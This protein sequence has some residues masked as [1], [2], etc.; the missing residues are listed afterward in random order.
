MARPAGKGW[1]CRGREIRR[2]PVSENVPFPCIS[3][4]VYREKG[5]EDLSVPYVKRTVKAGEVIETW[6]GH[7]P[8]VHPNGAKRAK[9]FKDTEKAQMDANERRAE[10]NLRWQLNANFSKNDMHVVLQYWEKPTSIDEMEEDARKFLSVL[11]KECKKFGIVLKYVLAFETKRM[12]N[13]HI[14]IVL[15]KMSMEI[16]T[17]S[18]AKVTKLGSANF[19]PLD[20]RGNHAELASYFIKE[21]KSTVARWK[22]GQKHK[23]RFWCSKNLEHPEPK[24]EIIQSN[25]WKKEPKAREG[26]ALY[27]D[28][29]GVTVHNGVSE[30]TGYA[31]QEYFEV[32]IHPNPIRRG[33]P[34]TVRSATAPLPLGKGGKIC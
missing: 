12:S 10:A 30:I 11:R 7:T 14:H 29:N 4:V 32:K 24:Y 27:K 33:N 20:D 28:K 2:L 31:W 23:K 22:K 17:E 25:S 21:S 15:N 26:Y 8:R 6:K 13:P 3:G 16:I 34:S 18:W 19:K 5:R 9:N 1:G